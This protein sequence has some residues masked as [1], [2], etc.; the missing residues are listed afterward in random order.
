[1]ERGCGEHDPHWR[2]GTNLLFWGCSLISDDGDLNTIFLG[3]VGEDSHRWRHSTSQTPPEAHR[4]H[5]TLGSQGQAQLPTISDRTLNHPQMS[6]WV[7]QRPREI[8][9]GWAPIPWGPILLPDTATA[10]PS[11]LTWALPSSHPL[12]FHQS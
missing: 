11:Q 1:M 3:C 7:Q 9:V 12:H 10:E 6:C 4:V 8:T 5:Y 2:H